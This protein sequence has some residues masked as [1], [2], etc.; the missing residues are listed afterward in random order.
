METQKGGT[1]NDSVADRRLVQRFSIILINACHYLL[2]VGVS[3]KICK[4]I[5]KMSHLLCSNY[6]LSHI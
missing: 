6:T 3:A 4:P 5:L 2:T 1:G